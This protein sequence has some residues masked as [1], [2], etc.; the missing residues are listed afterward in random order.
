[1]VGTK[2]HAKFHVLAVQRLANRLFFFANQFVRW[3]RGHESTNFPRIRES[4][5]LPTNQRIFHE[6]ANPTNCP[7][8]NEFS[9]N[10]RI[11][12]TAHE[13]TNFSRIRESNEL[14][15]NQRIFREFTNP[16]NCS[17][18]NESNELPT[19][20]RIVHEFSNPTNCSRINESNESPR[21]NELSAD[22]RIQR[23]DSD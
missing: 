8:I 21:I 9:T 1:M 15:T 17:R 12:R 10:S 18:I 6:F 20:Q 14:S 11:Q 3:I 5:E 2:V 22:S 7:R 16:T 4:N 13:S 19:N 23:I